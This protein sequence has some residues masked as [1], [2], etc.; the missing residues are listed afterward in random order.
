MLRSANV[1]SQEQMQPMQGM[2]YGMSEPEDSHSPRETRI[3]FIPPEYR[4]TYS[5]Q[6]SQPGTPNTVRSMA[7][8]RE[9]AESTANM[10]MKPSFQ[11]LIPDELT[12]RE[13][14]HRLMQGEHVYNLMHAN[15]PQAMAAMV[16]H[17][18]P[19]LAMPAIIVR[20]SD[21]QNLTMLAQTGGEETYEAS[22]DFAQTE[23]ENRAL[24]SEVGTQ[25]EQISLS[26]NYSST[27]VVHEEEL[28]LNLRKY[29]QVISTIEHEF[30]ESELKMQDVEEMKEKVM[31]YWEA[32]EEDSENQRIPVSEVENL[33][34]MFRSLVSTLDKEEQ[35]MYQNMTEQKKVKVPEFNCL[36]DGQEQTNDKNADGEMRQAQETE[37]SGEQYVNEENPSV[38]A[39]LAREISP[40]QNQ[41]DNMVFVNEADNN[42]MQNQ[43]QQQYWPSNGVAESDIDF[44]SSLIND[45]FIEE[46]EQIYEWVGEDG[47][48][49]D[50][51]GPAK[52]DSIG[53]S[54]VLMLEPTFSRDSDKEMTEGEKS[55]EDES[56]SMTV[57]PVDQVT[58]W[59]EQENSVNTL[60]WQSQE[61]ERQMETFRAAWRRYQ[62]AMAASLARYQ[63]TMEQRWSDDETD[64]EQDHAYRHEPGYWES[65]D[66]Q[67]SENSATASGLAGV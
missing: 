53:D 28:Q 38:T 47:Y 13:E 20:K 30:N 35:K 52:E 32:A 8:A 26:D 14:T 67:S 3:A 56:K 45:Q 10:A 55:K 4:T 48:P 65:V 27:T 25:T 42:L 36:M 33:I 50:P 54:S 29:L 23:P 61:R 2:I 60:T 59:Q 24:V 21:G 41:F 66:Q 17:S 39:E 49:R 1:A 40:E 22:N 12:S 18:E 5:P 16:V 46:L 7:G 15:R 6:F 9:Q 58:H 34:D 57:Q 43:Q 31:Q 62:S 63:S 51:G 37:M 44:L 19:R 64:D 11:G